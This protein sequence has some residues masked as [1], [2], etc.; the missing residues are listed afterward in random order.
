MQKWPN[1]GQR[2]FLS[3]LFRFLYLIWN[4]SSSSCSLDFSTSLSS[5]SFF[6]CWYFFRARCRLTS[7]SSTNFSNFIALSFICRR[8]KWHQNCHQMNQTRHQR[9]K[10][11]PWFLT[12]ACF[13]RSAALLCSRACMRLLNSSR[14]WINCLFTSS[15][16]TCVFSSSVLWRVLTPV[17]K[18]LLD[19]CTLAH[20]FRNSR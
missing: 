1:S 8:D 20:K 17:F 5:F 16:C 6:S 15:S 4:C 11:N 9:T 3:F 14:F 12:S 7:F 2:W 10:A 18:I 13:S 19:D